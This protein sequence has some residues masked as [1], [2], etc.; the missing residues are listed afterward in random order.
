MATFSIEDFKKENFNELV[1]INDKLKI[2]FDNLDE[3]KKNLTRLITE[4]DDLRQAIFFKKEKMKNELNKKEIKT[5]KENIELLTKNIE[6]LKLN[7]VDCFKEIIDTKK[8]LDELKL[9]QRIINLVCDIKK[10]EFE[11]IENAIKNEDFETLR[12]LCFAFKTLRDISNFD[13]ESLTENISNYNKKIEKMITETF[14]R[15]IVEKNRTLLR[16]S[17]VCFMEMDKSK[18][19]IKNY[20]QSLDLFKLKVSEYNHEIP[21]K[22][23]L[24]FYENENNPFFIFI[25]KIRKYY[26]DELSDIESIFPNHLEVIEIINKRIFQDLIQTE[27]ENFMKFEDSFLFL[28]NLKSSYIKVKELQKFI[29]SIYEE[30]IGNTLVDDIF[31][32]YV[33]NAIRKEETAFE[34]VFQ[35]LVNKKKP[36]NNYI[37]L[38]E[39]IYNSNFEYKEI[40]AKLLCIIN[41][42]MERAEILNYSEK[43][44]DEILTFFISKLHRLIEIVINTFSGTETLKLCNL[45]S[46]LFLIFSNFFSSFPRKSHLSENFKSFVDDKIQEIIDTRFKISE[47]KVKGL[48][49]AQTMKEYYDEAVN[50]ISIKKITCFLKD[51]NIILNETIPGKNT[52]DFLT[53]LLDK[54]Y[55]CYYKHILSLK[56]TPKKAK[57]LVNDIK[58]LQKFIKDINLIEVFENYEYFTEVCELIAV[59]KNDIIM[60]TTGMFH[61]IPRNE[62]KKILKCREDYHEIKQSVLEADAYS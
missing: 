24:D 46:Y 54:I 55:I 29:L 8:H 17:Y 23:D 15:A 14:E 41:F 3:T 19:I 1:L 13:N 62:L 49:K 21:K 32:D 39:S 25:S 11:K 57:I 6:N 52:K 37:L 56:F 58:Y 43:N 4:L 9:M 12:F 16:H 5:V 22:I 40:F 51:E 42:F 45:L 7:H 59:D 2:D 36:K 20:M 18:Y 60:F 30:S 61:K 28:M 33:L 34:E 26:D 35:I 48:I 31:E 53:L 47:R 38:N 50:T 10:R 44:I 27:L